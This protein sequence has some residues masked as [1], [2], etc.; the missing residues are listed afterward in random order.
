MCALLAWT[1]LASS[2]A[3]AQAAEDP[4]Y[5][6]VLATA[7]KEFDAGNW[8]E[9][10]SLMQQAHEIEPSARTFRG[11]GLCSYELR[12][13][14]SAERELRQSLDDQRRPL[15]AKQRAEIEEI[16]G[17]ATRFVSRYKVHVKPEAAALR[18]DGNPLQLGADGELA[19]NPGTHRIEGELKVIN[20]TCSS[21][22]QPV[23][24]AR[25]ISTSRW[26]R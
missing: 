10:K 4:Q 6:R 14:V 9:A 21:C 15:T 25:R 22:A 1:W 17:R 11:M 13:Y 12:D 5:R 20:R 23:V 26:W 19:L 2:S 16:L 24:R 18:V 7:L 3:A 8:E